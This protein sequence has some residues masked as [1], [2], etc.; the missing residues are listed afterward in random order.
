VLSAV[1]ADVSKKRASSEAAAL[2]GGVAPA[3][4]T[5]QFVPLKLAF[6]GVVDHALLAALAEE[7][8]HE[9]IMVKMAWALS[10]RPE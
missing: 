9:R 10:N 1:V 6:A 3:M 7:A 5:V 4:P 8:V 2:V